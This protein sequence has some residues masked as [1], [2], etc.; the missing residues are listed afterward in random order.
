MHRSWFNFAFPFQNVHFTMGLSLTKK[1][2]SCAMYFT[3]GV[4]QTI[5][6]F[7]EIINYKSEIENQLGYSLEWREKVN[8]KNSDI[9]LVKYDTD[10]KNK[11]NW[12]SYYE[13]FFT[14]AKKFYNTFPGFIDKLHI[15]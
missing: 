14:H 1:Y 3:G 2:I 5:S 15:D 7:K 12:N 13:W 8:R 11:D 6:T 10:Y 4:D 9:R